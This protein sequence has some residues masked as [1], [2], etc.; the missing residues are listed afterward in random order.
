MGLRVDQQAALGWLGIEGYRPSGRVPPLARRRAVPAQW[1]DERPDERPEEPPLE[2]GRAALTPGASH[3]PHP[4]G[5]ESGPDSPAERSPAPASSEP[6]A[7][8]DAPP[9]HVS[10]TPGSAHREL[11]EA[12]ARVAGLPCETGDGDDLLR[13]GGETWELAA[14]ATDGRAKR[15]LWRVLVA[16]RTRPRR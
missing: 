3:T 7:P 6:A 1:P 2:D 16:R 12:I 5:G 15:R 13:L 9:D 14:L 8:D 11:A 4:G 10:L